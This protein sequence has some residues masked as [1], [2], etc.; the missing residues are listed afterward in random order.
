MDEK[1]YLIDKNNDNL[2]KLPILHKGMLHILLK[3]YKRK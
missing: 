2:N 3:I 1:L